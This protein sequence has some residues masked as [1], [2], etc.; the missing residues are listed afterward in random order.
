MEATIRHVFDWRG[1]CEKVEE[2]CRTCPMSKKQRKQYGILP[3]KEAETIPWK[4]VNV[5]VVG[6]YIKRKRMLAMTM[7]DLSK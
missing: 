6:P 1:L 4:R 2:H 5:D 7:I 3:L